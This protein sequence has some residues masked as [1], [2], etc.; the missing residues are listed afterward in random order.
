MA[1]IKATGV[2]LTPSFEARGTSN[3]QITNNTFTKLTFPSE[4]FDTDNA[5]SVSN[6]EFTV[7]TGK[8]G[9]YFFS[10]QAESV[11]HND[12]FILQF[13]VNDVSQSLRRNVHHGNDSADD[14]GISTSALFDLSDGDTVSVDGYKGAVTGNIRY[15]FFQGFRI[16]D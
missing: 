8:G 6:S 13:V 1:L 10:A 15:K 9:K 14:P 5:F 11:N 16:G 3:Q 4:G 7:P 12:Q 2:N